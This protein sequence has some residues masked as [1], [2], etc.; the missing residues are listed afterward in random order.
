MELDNLKSFFEPEES[1][2]SLPSKSDIILSQ[3]KYVKAMKSLSPTSPF[4]STI[5]QKNLLNLLRCS[6]GSL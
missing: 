4:F 3:E 1:Q 2:L 5:S 6:G